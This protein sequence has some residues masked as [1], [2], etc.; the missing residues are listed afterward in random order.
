MFWILNFKSVWIL[1]KTTNYFV[2]TNI[3]S[4]YANSSYIYYLYL[5]ENWIEGEKREF[6]GKFVVEF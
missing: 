2:N 4:A 1:F 6:Y 5:K 3:L